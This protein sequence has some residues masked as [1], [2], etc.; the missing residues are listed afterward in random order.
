MHVA[1]FRPE[2]DG[3]AFVN[4]W[5]WDATE[6]A[7][8]KSIVTE[9]VGVIEIVLSP[10]IW[11]LEG[12][13]LIAELGVPFIG[14]YLV[15]K[16][17]EAETNAI[18]DKIVGAITAENYGLCGGMAFTALD[19]WHKNWVLPRGISKDDQP[20]RTSPSGKILRDYIWNRLIQSLKDNAG[21]FLEWMA[22]LHFEK[23]PG[24]TWLRDRTKAEIDKL[25]ARINAGVPVTVGM[26]G[27]TANPFNNHQVLVYGYNDNPDGT[28]TLFIYDNNVPGVETTCKLDFSGSALSAV[29]SNA[30]SDA[31]KNRGPLRGIFCTTYTPMTPPR[32]VV[33]RKGLTV[34]P[35]VTGANN[36][37]KVQLTA[38]NLGY[39]ASPA[40]TMVVAGD[41]GVSAKESSAQTIAENGER[42]F[43]GTLSFAQIGGHK[44]GAVVSL[45][46]WGGMEIVKF[47][48]AESGT[49]SASGNVVV[50]GERLIDAVHGSVCEVSN[51]A[52]GQARY[53]VRVDDMGAN[54]KYH[55]EV[56]GATLVSDASAQQI[57]I[58]LP[59]SAGASYTLKVTVTRPDGGFSSG[60]DTFQTITSEAAAIQQIICKIGHIYTK[61]P[62][63]TDPGYPPIDQNR[64]ITPEEISQIG[65]L[66]T[67][68]GAVATSAAKAG[69]S[70]LI[71]GQTRADVLRQP[72]VKLKT[73]LG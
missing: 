17:I 11:A 43:N 16:T 29:E 21:T 61:A 55:W 27:T 23:G 72:A 70:L 13:V 39:H 71:T 20:Q 68:L 25:K 73:T 8:V 12:P 69:K 56:T 42:T 66:A 37:V 2:A 18:V 46:T 44:L 47:L 52:G 38:A 33:L 24:A 4:N 19:Y 57:Q 34:S 50:V 67:Q 15:Q 22:V 41:N 36:P 49:Q 31:V 40:L 5:T 1:K 59:P 10:L 3:F 9:A 64:V 6:T 60:S 28:T 53:T 32:S 62:V 7:V 14:P 45:G 63:F 48:P 65:T 35:A 30:N 58:Q 51:V 54:L 26:I